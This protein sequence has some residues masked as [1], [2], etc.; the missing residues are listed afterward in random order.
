MSYQE[1]LKNEDSQKSLG[2]EELI[3]DVAET[4]I[5]L[6]ERSGLSKADL[7]SRLGVSR[8]HVTQ[9]LNGSRNM[10]LRTLADIG[11]VL[12]QKVCFEFRTSRHS[13]LRFDWEDE[14][15]SYRP[16]NIFSIESAANMHAVYSEEDA[17]ECVEW[18]QKAA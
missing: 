3:L 12:H 9:I 17:S 4:I 16:V 14:S 11:T 2:R 1:W 7:A 13:A 8:A 10:T 5:S 18:N 15:R 6:L